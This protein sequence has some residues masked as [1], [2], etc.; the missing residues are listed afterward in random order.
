MADA[1]ILRITIPLQ[2]EKPKTQFR[3]WVHIAM[4]AMI[5]QRFFTFRAHLYPTKPLI[6]PTLSLLGYE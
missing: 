4:T 5:I 6:D 2:D 3:L 1:S